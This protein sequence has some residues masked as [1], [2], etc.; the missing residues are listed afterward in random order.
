MPTQPYLLKDGTR[1]PGVTTCLHSWLPGGPD[2][3][4]GWAVKQALAGKDFKA[5]RDKAADA[6]TLCHAAADAWAMGKEP[7]WE[8]PQE[9]VAKAKK[10]FGA[11]L[12]WAEQTK[13]RVTHTETPLVSEVYRF[14]GCLD[15][16][17]MNN[18][19]V[20]A[21]YKTSNSIRAQYL[22]QVGGYGILWDEN[23]PDDP[24]TG[25]YLILR[26]DREYGDFSHKW[27]PELDTGRKAFLLCRQLYEYEKELTKRAK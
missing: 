15:A 6:G 8:G 13:F 20:L 21:D 5:E 3:L 25:G 7:S 18:R 26:F 19:R 4:M 24:L 27:F 23:F 9:I 11:F 22:A 17:M 10:S 16:A 14:G 2:A 1:V 12:E